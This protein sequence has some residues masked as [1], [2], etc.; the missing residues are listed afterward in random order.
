M[1]ENTVADPTIRFELKF[2][3]E[4]RNEGKYRTDITV[5]RRSR[6]GDEH[7]DMPT[8]EGQAVGGDGT[9]PWPLC[10]FASGL[11]G[12]F[13]THLRMFAKH[14]D[15]P[16]NDF[17]VS[18]RCHWEARQSGAAPYQ[19][20]PIAFMLDIDLNAGTDDAGKIRLIRAASHGCFAEQS[21][22]PGLV[23]H[24]LKSGGGWIDV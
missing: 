20:T 14:L 18:T 8:D 7:Y 5:I 9:A 11:T 4:A 19:A 17:S 3:A 24:R 12:C 21:M 2:D 22:K 1:V 23:K 10:Y 16:L 13:A 6:L 15:I